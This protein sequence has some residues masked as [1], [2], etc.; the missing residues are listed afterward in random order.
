MKVCTISGVTI[1]INPGVL[2]VFVGA[3]VFDMLGSL[4]QSF[5][6]LVLHE[7]SHAVAAYSMGY[8]FSCIELMPY[9]GV[10]NISQSV[11]SPRAEF[12]IA[13]AGPVSNFFIA[14]A[15]AVAMNFFPPLENTLNYFLTI[16]LALAFFN[17]L[18][19]APLDGGRMLS[20]I[21]SKIMSISAAVKTSAVAGI[22]TSLLML[23]AWG[24]L[25]YC[26]AVNIFLLVMG[27][28]LI[29]GAVKEFLKLP[30]AKLT[31]M[32]KRSDALHHGESIRARS[33]VV[34]TETKARSALREL[35]SYSYTFMHVVD[36]NM[37][38]VGLVDEYSLLNGISKF[39]PNVTVG[40]LVKM[41]V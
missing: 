39:G 26:G 8:K 40:E 21:L 5:L 35:S 6:T 16:N 30:E 17:M 11:I 18:P 14:G 23:G 3:F 10:A 4:L 12:I 2:L 31:A 9:G 36:K 29:I 15:L 33:V 13:M 37:K 25:L 1:K 38:H 19:A 41:R 27:V 34:N 20:S 7:L 22:I 24:Y 28:F 32:V